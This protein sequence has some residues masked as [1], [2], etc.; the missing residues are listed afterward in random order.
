MFYHEIDGG[1]R[2]AQDRVPHGAVAALDYDV[3]Q[4]GYADLL[5]KLRQA[6]LAGQWESQQMGGQWQVLNPAGLPDAPDFPTY[7]CCLGGLGAGQIFEIGRALWPD[8]KAKTDLTAAILHPGSAVLRERRDTIAAMTGVISRLHSFE[9]PV[10]IP[11][12]RRNLER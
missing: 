9:R 3:A 2:V 12:R 7:A 6:E 11:L 10:K 1:A 4:K 8:R 5:S